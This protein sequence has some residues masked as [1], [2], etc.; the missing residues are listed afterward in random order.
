[1]LSSSTTWTPGIIPPSWSIAPT[2]PRAAAAPGWAPSTRMLPE[3]GGMRPRSIE[4]VVVLPAPF[5]PSRA[6]VWPRS[7]ARLRLSTASTGPKLRLTASSTTAWGPSPSL[8]RP[9]VCCVMCHS[10]RGVPGPR[11]VKP[12]SNP[13]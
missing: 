10:V 11:V 8:G 7:T 5:G 6:S 4:I 3:S 2:R 13:R 9:E 12:V 1:M